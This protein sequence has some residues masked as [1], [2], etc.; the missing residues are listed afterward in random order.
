M[1]KPQTP[2]RKHRVFN[3][4]DIVRVIHIPNVGPEHN[5][6]YIGRICEFK[7]H[8]ASRDEIIEVQNLEGGY[9]W[10]THPRWCR[11]LTEQEMAIWKV[12]L[13]LQGKSVS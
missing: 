3:L 11:R 6:P 1:H 10:N 13:R 9:S 8:T 7:K 2:R 5:V 12:T 4:G